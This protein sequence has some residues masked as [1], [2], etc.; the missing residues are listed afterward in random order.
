MPPYRAEGSLPI[1]LHYGGPRGVLVLMASQSSGQVFASYDNGATW[2]SVLA[3]PSPVFDLAFSP[4]LNRVVAPLNVNASNRYSDDR[5]DTWQIGVQPGLT[6]W[7]RIAHGGPP[8]ARRFV[9]V[10][11][12]AT[13][14]G[15]LARSDTGIG[16]WTLI[17]LAS[18]SNLTAGDVY[19]DEDRQLWAYVGVNLTQ[20]VCHTSPDAVAWT[21]VFSVALGGTV[22]RVFTQPGTTPR[23]V[24]MC[25]GASQP[26]Y[27]S[28]AADLSFWSQIVQ[29]FNG[30]KPAGAASE[31]MCVVSGPGGNPV[32]T[33]PQGNSGTWTNRTAP[34]FP[35]SSD[36]IY[37]PELERF[38][39][40]SLNV[41]PGI[42][43]SANPAL[44]AAGWTQHSNDPNFDGSFLA[45]V[46]Q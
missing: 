41:N 32:Y 24:F 33:S 20:F 14:N 40:M 4:E 8:G 26:R 2:A 13:L 30:E 10:N 11:E 38:F 9:M 12:A 25:Q 3:A 19:W 21:Q 6:Q 34:F 23:R 7:R 36:G 44:G 17:N 28:D 5:G 37:V 39:W 15:K 45:A 27:L 1:G 22:T 43:S 29:A 42:Y 18:A 16:A 46:M 35:G 31:N